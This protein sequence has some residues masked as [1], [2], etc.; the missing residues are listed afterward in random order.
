M[1]NLWQL[2][3]SLY[4]VTL[5]QPRTF[6]PVMSCHN[7]P[8]SKASQANERAHLGSGANAAPRAPFGVGGERETALNARAVMPTSE[9]WL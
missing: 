1:S 6:C 9:P 5:V 7:L 2:R 4:C 3:W 8:G